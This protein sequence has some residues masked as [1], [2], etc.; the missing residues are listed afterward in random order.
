M[1]TNR[2]RITDGT[3]AIGTAP[4]FG[5]QLDDDMIKRYRVS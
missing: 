2:P 4:G 3:M 5:L 1:W